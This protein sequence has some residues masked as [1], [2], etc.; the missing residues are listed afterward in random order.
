MPDGCIDVYRVA[1]IASHSGNISL[2]FVRNTRIGFKEIQM[3]KILANPMQLK[4]GSRRGKMWKQDLKKVAM[5]AVGVGGAY[6]LY[7]STR[8]QRTNSI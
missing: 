7:N 4:K 5:V 1:E 6:A 2:S 8:Q 3:D